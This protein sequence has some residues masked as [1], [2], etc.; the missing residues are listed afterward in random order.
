[1]SENLLSLLSFPFKFLGQSGHFRRNHAQ[2]S[3]KN[4]ITLLRHIIPPKP[5]LCF[6]HS[7]FF[8]SVVGAFSHKIIRFTD[9]P[10]STWGG[11]GFPPGA[12]GI[13]KGHPGCDQMVGCG[14]LQATPVHPVNPK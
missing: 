14:Q 5:K 13:T 10:K 7:L 12:G 1:M 3:L 11:D 8:F 4:L 9:S 6:Q 2:K